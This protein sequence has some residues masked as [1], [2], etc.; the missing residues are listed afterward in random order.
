MGLKGLEL[1]ALL[2]AGDF[3]K[4]FKPTKMKTVPKQLSGMK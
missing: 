1:Q 4:V 3:L 2:L